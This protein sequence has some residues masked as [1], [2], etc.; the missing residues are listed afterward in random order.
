MPSVKNVLSM[1]F[2]PEQTQ[3]GLAVLRVCTGLSLFLRHGWEKRQWAQFTAHFSR[4]HRDRAAC[5]IPYRVCRCL[6]CH[7]PHHELSTETTDCDPKCQA[8][9]G[10]G[11]PGAK[12]CPVSKSKCASCDMPKLELPGA[13]YKF[14]DHRIRIVKPTCSL[15]RFWT[16]SMVTRFSCEAMMFR[17]TCCAVVNETI[18]PVSEA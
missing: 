5:F 6:A 3:L 10:G 12:A 2:V 7:D 8:C 18:V 1:R 14:S 15:T 16:R 9:H 13:H 17:R 4:S 11:K